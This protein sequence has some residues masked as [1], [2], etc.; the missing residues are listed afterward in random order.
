MCYKLR[1]MCK[2]KSGTTLL[3]L[4]VAIS[5]F[6]VVVLIATETFQSVMAGQQNAIAAQNTQESMRYFLEMMS[7]EVRTAMG[8]N[9][10]T[11]CYD[12]TPADN[13]L[14]GGEFKVFNVSDSTG[15][16]DEGRALHFR[17]KEGECVT[18]KLDGGRIV[19]SRKEEDGT[20]IFEGNITPDEIAV[21]DLF[22]YVVDDEVD[23]FHSLQPIVTVRLNAESGI[24]KQIFKN[25]MSIQTSISSRYYEGS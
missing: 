13:A 6:T 2:D 21:S 5:L 22:F 24:S 12:E 4:M 9:S 20:L 11:L 10:G 14:S 17:N 19:V 8:T 18:Y 7:R 16:V 25:K 15:P 3:E 23:T 1:E